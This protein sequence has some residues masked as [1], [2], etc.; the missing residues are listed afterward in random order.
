MKGLSPLPRVRQS[1]VGGS[2]DISGDQRIQ[3]L[4]CGARRLARYLIHFH[5]EHSLLVAIDF[6]SGQHVNLFHQK[7]R[8]SSAVQVVC[9]LRQ[10][11]RRLRILITFP[12][13]LDGFHL[14]ILLH[15]MVRIAAQQ[16]L[17]LHEIM[18]LCQFYRQ[19]PIVQQHAH[20]HSSLQIA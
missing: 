13:E 8:H 9:D 1:F 3:S 7:R 16:P 17:N 6:Q 5:I 4:S 18:I 19:I 15:Q 11:L 10:Q 12:V 20:I 14:F 2:I